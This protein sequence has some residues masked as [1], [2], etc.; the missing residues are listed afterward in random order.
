VFAIR[1][2]VQI[3]AQRPVILTLLFLWFSAVPPSSG[4]KFQLKIGYREAKT[5]QKSR[6]HLKI[7]GAKMVTS[8]EFS[9]EN[10]QISDAKVQNL[11]ARCLCSPELLPLPSA[12]FKLNYFLSSCRSMLCNPGVVAYKELIYK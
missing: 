12:P 10:P 9:T 8:S 7:L 5:F 11:V 6:I 4:S 3:S 1:P 2:R